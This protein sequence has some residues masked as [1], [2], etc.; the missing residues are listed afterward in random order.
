M[1]FGNRTAP[2]DSVVTEAKLS[3]AQLR[4]HISRLFVIMI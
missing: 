3:F 1:F 2:N 4:R